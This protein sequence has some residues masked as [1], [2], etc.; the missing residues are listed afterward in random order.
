LYGRNLKKGYPETLD[1]LCV[2]LPLAVLDEG[3]FGAKQSQAKGPRPMAGAA[4]KASYA[5]VIGG[6][7]TPL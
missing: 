4:F 3:F 2:E 1:F 5:A 6:V 7:P